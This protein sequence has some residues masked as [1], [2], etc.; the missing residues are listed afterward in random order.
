MYS[1][2]PLML[3]TAYVKI[4]SLMSRLMI[5]SGSDRQRTGSE[6]FTRCSVHSTSRPRESRP[7]SS[8]C[9][10]S[11][12]QRSGEPTVSASSTLPPQ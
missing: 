9:S 6:L 10:C 11:G 7:H 3:M 1:Y 8:F 2:R 4:S 12:V 5:A